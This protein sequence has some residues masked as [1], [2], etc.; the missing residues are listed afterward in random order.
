MLVKDSYLVK[1]LQL[2]HDEEGKSLILFTHSCRCSQPLSGT[3]PSVTPSAGSQPSL[4]PLLR[5]CQ[6][7]ALLLRALGIPCAP[8]HSIL[9]QAERLA[10][11]AKF[12]AGR[13][14]VLVATDV[15]SR[16]GVCS[17]CVGGGATCCM[18]CMSVYS[19]YSILCQHC[20]CRGLDIPT[21]DVVVNSN[22]PASPKDYIHRVGRT[23]RA[24]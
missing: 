15:A 19:F 6:V 8:L 5:S 13:V 22:V 3:F 23:A 16:F 18:C 1:L 2:E 11:L 7:Y 21:V 24:G 14:R 17:S 12:R 9:G 4:L 20:C 10:T